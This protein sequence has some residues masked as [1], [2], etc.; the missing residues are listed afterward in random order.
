MSTPPQDPRVQIA[1]LPPSDPESPGYAELSAIGEEEEPP[2]AARFIDRAWLQQDAPRRGAGLSTLGL[3][4][5]AGH[6]ELA[7]VNVPTALI[8]GGIA[9][10]EKLAAYVLAGGRLDDG[11]LMQLDEGLPSL[12]GFELDRDTGLLGVIF[13]S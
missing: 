2:P 9:L 3:E 12:I 13:I 7:I 4:V 11:E 8:S 6:P 1:V 5:H 10:L